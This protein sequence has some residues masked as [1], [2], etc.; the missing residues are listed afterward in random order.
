MFRLPWDI[1]RAGILDN[2]SNKKTAIAS[3][4]SSFWFLAFNC[5]LYNLLYVRHGHVRIYTRLFPF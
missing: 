4:L 2:L 3:I 5:V 1:S